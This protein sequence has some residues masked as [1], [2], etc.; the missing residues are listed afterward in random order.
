MAQIC[1]KCHYHNSYGSHYCVKCGALLPGYREYVVIAKTELKSLRDERDLLREQINNSWGIK[2]KKIVG[3][4][5]DTIVWTA[6]K[7]FWMIA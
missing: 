4:H 2:I 1:S 7:V 6:S 5:I 3:D